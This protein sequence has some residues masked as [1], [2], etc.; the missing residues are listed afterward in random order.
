MI[1]RFSRTIL[2]GKVI[3]FYKIMTP[4]VLV[5]SLVG[6]SNA[7]SLHDSVEAIVTN[8]FSEPSSLILF[9]ICLIVLSRI[10]KRLL[11]S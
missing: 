10:S 7:S 9:G 5:L 1:K 3:K 2:E 6:T 8:S 11:S 4:M